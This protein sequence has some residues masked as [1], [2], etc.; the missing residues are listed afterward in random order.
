MQLDAV[1]GNHD[2]LGEIV[3]AHG[4]PFHHVAFPPP[5]N[6]RYAAEKEKAFD[7]LSGLVEGYDPRRDRARALH[8]DPARRSCARRGPG[9]RSTSTTA[10]CPRSSAPGPTTRPTRAE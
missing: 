4:A 10:S 3:R 6:V 1:I 5:G 9:G 2:E 8:A 7:E